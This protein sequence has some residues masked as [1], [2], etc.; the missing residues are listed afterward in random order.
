MDFPGSDS[1]LNID[2]VAPAIE[3][4]LPSTPWLPMR[5][6]VETRSLQTL[7]LEALEAIDALMLGHEIGLSVLA[8]RYSEAVEA[9]S[10]ERICG[11]LA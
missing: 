10:P 8:E 9:E 4:E 11:E 7:K 3:A 5:E 6:R 1:D 2:S